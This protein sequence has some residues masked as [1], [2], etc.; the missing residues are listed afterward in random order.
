[1]MEKQQQQQQQRS[2]SDLQAR[3]QDGLGTDAGV[4][5]PA[6]KDGRSRELESKET[7]LEIKENRKKKEDGEDL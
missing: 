1:M 6:T 3:S 2:S 4:A 5:T 7:N